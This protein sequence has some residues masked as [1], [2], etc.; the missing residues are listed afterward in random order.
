MPIYME[1]MVYQEY[2]KYEVLAAV[3][4]EPFYNTRCLFSISS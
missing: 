2:I 3:A 4:I 1:C